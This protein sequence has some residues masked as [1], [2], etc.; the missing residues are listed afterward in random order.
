M[1]NIRPTAGAVLFLLWR[2]YCTF[3]IGHAHDNEVARACDRGERFDERVKLF[4][5][6]GKQLAAAKRGATIILLKTKAA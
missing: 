3:A 4:Q 1:G 2:G 6:W 5:W